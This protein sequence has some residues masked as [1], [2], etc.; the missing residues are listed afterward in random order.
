MF[1]QT[2]VNKE[3]TE[4]TIL[5]HFMFKDKFESDSSLAN[6]LISSCE[7]KTLQVL[8]SFIHFARFRISGLLSQEKEA[9]NSC[10]SRLLKSTIS[11]ART[12]IE[13]ARI[14]PL[15]IQVSHKLQS[16]HKAIDSK[17]TAD[18]NGTCQKFILSKGVFSDTVWHDLSLMLPDFTNSA[19]KKLSTS[20][21]KDYNSHLLNCPTPSKIQ[22][23]DIASSISHKY[24]Q[25]KELPTFP[26]SGSGSSKCKYSKREKRNYNTILE[27]PKMEFSDQSLDSFV[28]NSLRETPDS[29]EHSEGGMLL[30]GDAEK[31]PEF[32]PDLASLLDSDV[33]S[34][35][36]PHEES[37]EDVIVLGVKRPTYQE[38]TLEEDDDGKVYESNV[39]VVEKPVQKE[40]EIEELLFNCSMCDK[41][42][43]VE[44]LL[45]FH[46]RMHGAETSPSFL[47]NPSPDSCPSSEEDNSSENIPRKSKS[48]KREKENHLKVSSKSYS[49]RKSHHQKHHK[50]RKKELS[51]SSL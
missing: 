24:S 51:K 27:L 19:K 18:Q 2:A 33:S 15:Q 4:F 28:Y 47:E 7:D 16:L 40:N 32:L 44:S 42:Y 26:S 6:S 14:N 23:C 9:E 10:R 46:L 37:D 13:T 20:L 22:S 29:D 45:K 50:R 39:K 41:S 49:I 30:L 5:L 34:S 1:L 21:T 8:Q 12:H 25:I 38:I 43:R 17:V 31:A 35:S 48:S 3:I 11:F 36:P